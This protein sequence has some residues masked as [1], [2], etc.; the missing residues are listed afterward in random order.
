MRKLHR[1]T[2]T[3][4]PALFTISSGLLGQTIN[5]YK[6]IEPNISLSLDSNYFKISN[7]Y[8]NETYGTEIYDFLYSVDSLRKMLLQISADHPVKYPPKKVTDSIVVSKTEEIRK[9]QSDTFSIINIDKQ[10]KDIN[11]FSCIG[12]VA[13]NKMSGKYSTVISGYHYSDN[14][15][16]HLTCMSNYNDLDTAYIILTNFLAGFRSYSYLEIENE[17]SLIKKK[18]SV[19]VNPYKTE[20]DVY[21]YRRKTFI[22]LVSTNEKINHTIAGARLSFWGGFESFTPDKDGK[23]IILS[24]DSEKGTI[25][26][27]GELIILNSFGKKV[28]VPFSF[29]YQNT[30]PL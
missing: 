8:S 18:Y 26:K 3:I 10:I 6:F 2:L 12:F 15:K 19:M 28:K 16:T 11:G 29:T 30:G 22:G 1:Y 9:M 25:I 27:K 14:D 21:K 20:S 23:L 13:Y 7:R 5:T 24:N 17:E 4:I